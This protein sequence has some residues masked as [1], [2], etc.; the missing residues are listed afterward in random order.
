MVAA[1]GLDALVRR[2]RTA[3]Q[4]L[5]PLV[6]VDAVG[7]ERAVRAVRAV[8]DELARCTTAEDLAAAYRTR[9]AWLER[10]VR[11]VGLGGD[12]TMLELVAEAGFSLRYDA[13]TGEVRAEAVRRRIEEAAGRP[14]WIVLLED[15]ELRPAGPSTWRRVDV[16][17]PDGVGLALSVGVDQET[18]ST[19]Y[20]VEV[21]RLD[22][23]TGDVVGAAE[24]AR[25]FA[26]RAT[27]EAAVAALRTRHVPGH[28]VERELDTAE[29]AVSY[30]IR[31][32][33]TG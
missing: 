13:L 31:A 14:G 15:G 2:W 28:A 5:Y 12:P 29:K 21:L 25:R 16:N 6:L 22:R 20:A 19:A 7:Y 23:R 32:F 24:P 30:T 9:L 27:W 18:G 4:R 10:T 8:A 11:P 3:E 17:L 1:E 33:T 26:D